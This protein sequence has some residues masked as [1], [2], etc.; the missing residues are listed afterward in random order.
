MPVNIRLGCEGLTMTT[1]LAYFYTAVMRFMLQAN[2]VFYREL[3][4]KTFYSG[5]LRIFVT[6]LVLGKTFQP[7]LMF[8]DEARN[9]P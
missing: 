1:T 6:S 7:S 9:L 2:N 8:V 4:Y 5:N 3:N